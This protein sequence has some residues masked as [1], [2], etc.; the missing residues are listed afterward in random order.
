METEEEWEFV[1]NQVQKLTN[2]FLDDWHIGLQK[3][4]GRWTWVSGK[5][6]TINKW[7]P[8]E[9]FGDGPYT[10]MSKNYP[11]GSYGL[12]NDLSDYVPKGYI[13]EKPKG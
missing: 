7:Q 6:L 10:V 13:C 3:L 12:F 2:Q 1:N 8:G 4:Q 9:P 11:I 5:P